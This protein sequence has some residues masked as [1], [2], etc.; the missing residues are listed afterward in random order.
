MKLT[1]KL[2]EMDDTEFNILINKTTLSVHVVCYEGR[3][4]RDRAS[5]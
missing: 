3:K 1:C 5:D 2:G 4:E